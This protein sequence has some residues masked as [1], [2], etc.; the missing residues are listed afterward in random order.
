MDY[1]LVSLFITFVVWICIQTNRRKS[2]LPPG[3]RPFPIIG[4]LLEL[5]NKPHH[6]LTKLSKT[7]GPI[8]TLQTGSIT[9]IVVSSSHTAQQVLKKHDRSLSSRTIPDAM[10][11]I[12]HHHFS[13]VFLPASAQWRKLRKICNSQIFTTQ[14]LD[15]GEALRYKKVQELMGHVRDSCTSIEAI[16]IGRVAFTTTLNLISNSIF[17]T[18]LAH[19]NSNL[20]QEFKDL[21]WSVLEETGTP[22]IADFLPFLRLLDPQGVRRRVTIS[23]NKLMEFFDGIITQR[24]KIRAPSLAATNNRDMLDAA[25]DLTELSSNELKHLLL[26]LFVAGSDTTSSTMEWV[27]AELLHNPITMAKVQAEVRRVIGMDKSVQESDITNLPYL[28][29]VVKETLRLHPPVPFL[30]PHKAE[31]DVEID[32]FVVPK[33]AQILVNVWAIG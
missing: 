9:T 28:Q 20:S 21:V 30:V 22:N 27:M 1:L 23:C 4:N 31:T 12:N 33:D 6:S 25:L 19:Y 11:A 10:N 2:K 18:D 26:D 24:S 13:I 14:R 8:I 16:D 3:P 32:G 29:A 7:Y 17:S 5:A 15:G